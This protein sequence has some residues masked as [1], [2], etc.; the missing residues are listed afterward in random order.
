[1]L[2]TGHE[3]AFLADYAV[4][5]LTANAFAGAAGLYRSLLS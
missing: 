3:R 1:M 4:P 5:S 2:L